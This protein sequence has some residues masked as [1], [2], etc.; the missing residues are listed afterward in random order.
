MNAS[1]KGKYRVQPSDFQLPPAQVA[2]LNDARIEALCEIF[3]KVDAWLLLMTAKH[4]IL[5][6][7]IRERCALEQVSINGGMEYILYI[8]RAPVEKLTIVYTIDG[9]PQ[10]IGRF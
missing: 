10:H 9:Q 8:D 5:P 1:M 3:A 7:Y 2:A 6:E 4:W